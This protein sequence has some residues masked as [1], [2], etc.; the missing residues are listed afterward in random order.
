MNEGNLGE[1]FAALSKFQGSNR[2]NRK[3]KTGYG[4]KYADIESVIKAAQ[5]VSG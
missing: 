1:L 2:A 4:Y 5:A 3:A